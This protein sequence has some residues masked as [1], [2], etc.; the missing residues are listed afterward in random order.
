MSTFSIRTTAIACAL[1]ATAFFA[2]PATAGAQTPV[3]Q[4]PDTGSLGSMTDLFLDGAGEAFGAFLGG[5]VG[6]NGSITGM[7]GSAQGSL[8]DTDSLK[9]ARDTLVTGSSEGSVGSLGDMAAQINPDEIGNA[10]GGSNAASNDGSTMLKGVTG[11]SIT[12]VLDSASVGLEQLP[13]ANPS[14]TQPTP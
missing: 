7:V 9:N 2:M 10:A 13:A 3:I 14:P 5:S 4:G 11:G 1:G 6:E 12:G 8:G